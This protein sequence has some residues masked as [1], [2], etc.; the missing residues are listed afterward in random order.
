[1]ETRQATVCEHAPG[2][3]QAT[4]SCAEERPTRLWAIVDN[5]ERFLDSFKKG[6]DNLKRNSTKKDFRN[7]NHIEIIQI[8]VTLT[9][10]RGES[11]EEFQND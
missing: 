7:L 2:G 11:E 1:M 3:T 6:F 9:Q 4:S 8:H 5:N 10:E